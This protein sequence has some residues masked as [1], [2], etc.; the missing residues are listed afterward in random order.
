MAADQLP[1]SNRKGSAS[2]F[3]GEGSRLFFVD[4]VSVSFPVHR[5]APEDHWAKLSVRNR[6]DGREVT[7]SDSVEV[8]EGV[9]AMI[10]VSDIP[11]IEQQWA[12]IEVNPSRVL[13]PKGWSAEAGGVETLAVLDAAISKAISEGYF[14]P[15]IGKVEEANL[16]RLDVT[17]DFRNVTHPSFLIGG[18]IGVHRNY[19]RQSRVFYDP[20]R[21]GAQTLVTG[22]KRNQVRLYDKDVETGGEA[23]GVVRWE[24]LNRE[25][26]LK[27]HGTM[28]KAGDVT[29]ERI[30]QLGRNRFEWSGMGMRVVSSAQMVTEKIGALELSPSKQ[31]HVL[32]YLLQSAYGL[33]TKMSSST[34]A[35]Y[36]KIVREA[37]VM[38]ALDGLEESEGFT[39]HLDLEEGR[40]VVCV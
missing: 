22:G 33:P 4:K 5:S 7:R 17:R 29:D 32:G 13:D 40:E 9:H 8:F 25:D 21:S 27:E 14:D 35:E 19:G 31:R 34:A 36:R 23:A 3:E 11:A 12:K 20:K 37:G 1:P 24:G 16:K 18:L 2:V 6:P 38:M 26:W 10:G 30:E 39:V 15:S 28:S